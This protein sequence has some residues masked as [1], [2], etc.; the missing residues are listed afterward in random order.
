M[1]FYIVSRY[2]CDVYM[3]NGEERTLLLK[4]KVLMQKNQKVAG[5][6][7]NPPIIVHTG[8]TIEI[9]NIR[10]ERLP[11]DESVSS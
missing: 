4:D 5:V 9:D 1:A 8:E 7:F 2:I 11:D 10:Y 3:N 6:M